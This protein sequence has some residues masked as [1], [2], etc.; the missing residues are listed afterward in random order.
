MAATD[1]E[2]GSAARRFRLGMLVPYRHDWLG[3]NGNA[4]AETGAGD[5]VRR[6]L[7]LLI[8]RAQICF[9]SAFRDLWISRRAHMAKAIIFGMAVSAL[10]VFSATC[11]CWA[12]HLNYYVGWPE[13]GRLA[14][15]CSVWHRAGGRLRNRWMYRA[16]EGRVHY[17]RVGSSAQ[18]SVRP[19]PLLL[20]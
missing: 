3:V 19:S 7:G 6:R 10:L 15:C 8:E 20:G 2:T 16:V 14:D 11:S 1:A 4:S 12:L 9:T 13:C 5:A 18:I 17:W